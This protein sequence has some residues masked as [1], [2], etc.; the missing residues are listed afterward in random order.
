MNYPEFNP[1][2]EQSAHTDEDIRILQNEVTSLK[3][4]IK[5]LS[6]K[7]KLLKLEC[8]ELRASLHEADEN[9]EKLLG[10]YQHDVGEKI[11]YF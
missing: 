6:S 8:K 10:R 2:L 11:A 9:Y 3:A 4:Q 1:E 7:N 5:S